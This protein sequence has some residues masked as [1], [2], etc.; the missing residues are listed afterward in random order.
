MFRALLCPSS[1][2]HDYSADYHIDRPVLGLLLVGSYVQAGWVVSG[3][4]AAVG[5][6]LGWHVGWIIVRV[7]GC[8]WLEVRLAG[9]LDKCPVCRL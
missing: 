2:A 8:C 4:Q 9:R 6:K 3:L 5:W 7:A 1:G